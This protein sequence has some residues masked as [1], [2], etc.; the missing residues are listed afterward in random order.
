VQ[1]DKRKVFKLSQTYA[2]LRLRRSIAY[3]VVRKLRDLVSSGIDKLE[4]IKKID[5]FIKS[6]ETFVMV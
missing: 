4:I 5:D 2:K 3:N 6:A 1:G